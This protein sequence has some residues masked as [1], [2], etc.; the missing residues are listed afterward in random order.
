VSSAIPLDQQTIHCILF[1]HEHCDG[2]GYPAGL[3]GSNI[4]FPVRVVSVA[5][6]YDILTSRGI[7][8]ARLTP[9]EALAR[10]K[11]EMKEKIDMDVF[12]QLVLVVSGAGLVQNPRSEGP[13]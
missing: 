11:E 6:Y 7:D 10:M 8:G 4:P 13:S 3:S 1:H 5:N 9:F 2:S 12:K